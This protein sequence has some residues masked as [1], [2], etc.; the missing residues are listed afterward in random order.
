[1]K[2]I[3]MLF[4]LFFLTDVSALDYNHNLL[5]SNQLADT[6]SNKV[7]SNNPTQIVLFISD[8]AEPDYLYLAESVFDNNDLT[9]NQIIFTRPQGAFMKPISYCNSE[10]G[11][12]SI[13]T[14][15]TK[16]TISGVSLKFPLRILCKGLTS[17]YNESY[18]TFR[19]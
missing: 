14:D 6:Y 12:V 18:S 8:V 7:K 9:D 2:V 17:T 3:N 13:S 5:I 16:L 15:K 1:M 19:K 4:I 11:V 10:S